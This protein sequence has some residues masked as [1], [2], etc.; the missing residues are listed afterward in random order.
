MR[1]TP[2]PLDPVRQMFRQAASN[3][4]VRRLRILLTI[5]CALLASDL[6]YRECGAP[7]FGVSAPLMGRRT[8]PCER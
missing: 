2:C 7:G 8:V 6:A 3:R 1:L 5:C 4:R